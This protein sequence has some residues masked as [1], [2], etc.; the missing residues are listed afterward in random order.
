PHSKLIEIS[1]KLRRNHRHFLIKLVINPTG[2]SN[3]ETSPLFSVEVNHL[4]AFKIL[5][6]NSPCSDKS[7]FFI[8]SKKKF[9]RRLSNIFCFHKGKSSGT[10]NSVIRSKSCAIGLEPISLSESN[11][12]IC[13]KINFS[14]GSSVCHHVHVVLNNHCFVIFITF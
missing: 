5:G 2:A 9:K 3:V 12:R 10:T 8:C 11:N 13:I 1:F 6:L 14:I 7:C 4:F